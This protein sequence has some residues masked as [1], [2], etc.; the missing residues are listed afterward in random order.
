M[1]DSFVE[2]GTQGLHFC[3]VE[4]RAD[5]PPIDAN[6]AAK[7]EKL[8]ERTRLLAQRVVRPVRVR[9]CDSGR[10]RMT[11]LT[12]LKSDARRPRP[13]AVCS[14]KWSSAWVRNVEVGSLVVVL[15]VVVVGEGVCFLQE[16]RTIFSG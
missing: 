13:A 5:D 9:H 8:Y 15:V 16:G 1:A 11:A 6:A 4:T 2:E 7:L 10:S 14:A 12:A 3:R